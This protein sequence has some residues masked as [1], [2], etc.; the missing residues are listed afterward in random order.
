MQRN[1]LPLIAAATVLYGCDREFT[2]VDP[3]SGP[4]LDVSAASLP[5]VLGTAEVSASN[6][7]CAWDT[8]CAPSAAASAEAFTFRGAVGQAFLQ[9]RQLPPGEPGTA[10]EGLYGYEYRID[11]TELSTAGVEPFSISEV[12]IPFS[13]VSPVD[14]NGDGTLEHVYIVTTG[15]PGTIEPSA[16]TT[17]GNRIVIQFAPGTLS[18]GVGGLEGV[19]SLAIGLASPSPAGK[20]NA[21]MEEQLTGPVRVATMAPKP[22]QGQA[23]Q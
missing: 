17:Q 14:Y 11:L 7:D 10:A 23:L 2:G 6:V 13:S 19:S 21:W 20:S 15:G 16:V 18:G 4:Q 5:P 12:R 9:F 3:V 8:Q 1:M 22:G